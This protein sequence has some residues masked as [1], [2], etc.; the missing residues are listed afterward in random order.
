VHVALMFIC[1]Q[2]K[3]G[4]GG[5]YPVSIGFS[6]HTSHQLYAIAAA[7]CLFISA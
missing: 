1:S 3:P 6:F 7:S 4:P 2:H 5:P